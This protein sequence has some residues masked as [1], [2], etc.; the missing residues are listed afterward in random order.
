MSWFFGLVVIAFFGG[1][2][3]KLDQM[4]KDLFTIRQE[5]RIMQSRERTDGS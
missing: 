2:W 3:A 4:Q 1:I 5:L